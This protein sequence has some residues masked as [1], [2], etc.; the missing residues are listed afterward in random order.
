[1]RLRNPV[2]GILSFVISGLLLQVFKETSWAIFVE[3]ILEE[4]ATSL[5]IERAAM[6]ATL[7]QVLIGGGLLWAALYFAFR[8]GRA[9]RPSKPEADPESRAIPDAQSDPQWSRDVSLAGVLWQAFQGDW[10]NVRPRQTELEEERFQFTADQIRQHAFDGSLPCWGRRRGSNL[11]EPIP[12]EFWKNHAIQTS[13]SLRSKD[14]RE[15]WV[16]VTHP[17]VVGEVVNARTKAWEDFMTSNEAVEKLWPRT[18]P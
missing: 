7:S 12:R 14:N 1:M 18:T 6:V 4:V 9:E 17:L 10:M 11:F 8:V 16:Y 5:H 13:Y 3:R 15:L 2:F